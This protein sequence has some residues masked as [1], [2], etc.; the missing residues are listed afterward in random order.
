VSDD[1][2]S[3]AG[4]SPARVRSLAALARGR[5][6]T[7]GAKPVAPSGVEMRRASR[8]SVSTG[9]STL[10][11]VLAL[12]MTAS[13]RPTPGARRTRI[14]SSSSSARTSLSAGSSRRSASSS[15]RRR[16]TPPTPPS[17][18][19]RATGLPIRRP[20]TSPARTPSSTRSPRPRSRPPRSRLR[21]AA[22]APGARSSSSMPAT[23]GDSEACAAS[24]ASR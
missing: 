17:S 4:V 19:S 6:A 14:E 23:R 11:S 8:V 20:R 18:T 22:Y 21:G 1:G 15:P 7:L 3:G 24:E 2:H 16:L 10:A 13:T 9:A 12:T 5:Y